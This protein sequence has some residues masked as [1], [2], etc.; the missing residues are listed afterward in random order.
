METEDLIPVQ[1]IITHHKIEISFLDSL[2]EF[3]LIEI[4]TVKETRYLFK[5]QLSELEKMIRLHYELE[6][7]LEGIEA[8]SH[9]LQRVNSLQEE[10]VAARNRLRVYESG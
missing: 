1:E 7:N 5:G 9:L 3:G 10:L 6:I 8:I 4:T 2:H